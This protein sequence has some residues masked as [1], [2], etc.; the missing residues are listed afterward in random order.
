MATIVERRYGLGVPRRGV[1]WRSPPWCWRGARRAAAHRP[2]GLTRQA[3]TTYGNLSAR[4][5]LVT[6]G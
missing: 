6:S 3:G 1:G 5:A 4:A 2:C